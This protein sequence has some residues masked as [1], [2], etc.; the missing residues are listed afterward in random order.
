MKG[1]DEIASQAFQQSDDGTWIFFPRTRFFSGFE[2]P[3]AA[4]KVELQQQ[5]SQFLELSMWL[6]FAGLMLAGSFG[7][8]ISGAASLEV[9]MLFATAR[10]ARRASRGLVKSSVRFDPERSRRLFVERRSVRRLLAMQA[11]C[12]VMTFFA[13]YAL[14]LQPELWTTILPGVIFLAFSTFAWS[15]MMKIKFETRAIHQHAT[16]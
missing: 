4:R 16:K 2:V 10:F 8:L 15:R 11:L 7:H 9:A 13:I 5:F 6:V 1:F 3:S 14:E 12:I